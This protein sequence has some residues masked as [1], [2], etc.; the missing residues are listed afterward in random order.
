MTS[1]LVEDEWSASLPGRFSSGERARGT[2]WIG[3]W[4]GPRTGLDDVEKILDPTGTR[5]P[6]PRPSS[7]QSVTI[8]TELSRLRNLKRKKAKSRTKG[9]KEARNK[10]R[11]RWSQKAVGPVTWPRR[12]FP[13][14][15]YERQ[16]ARAHHSLLFVRKTHREGRGH[17]ERGESAAVGYEG[18]L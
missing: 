9:H 14:L 12:S 15:Q 6:T 17:P 7:L 1:E 8:P 4:V 18:R 10:W 13:T 11:D 3:G 5:T 2:H 16:I